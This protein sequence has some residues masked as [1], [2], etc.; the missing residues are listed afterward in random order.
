MKNNNTSHTQSNVSRR[1]F[2]TGA[3]ALT[4]S[5]TLPLD[6]LSFASLPGKKKLVV[7]MLRGGLDGLALFPPMGD[8]NYHK[9]RKGLALP[10][11]NSPGAPI[12]LNKLFGLHPMAEAFYPFWARK[13]MAFIPAA[14]LPNKDG[15][16][17][18]GQEL[19]ESGY[20]SIGSGDGTGWLGRALKL[21]KAGNEESF[22]AGDYLPLILQSKDGNGSLQFQPAHVAE[23]YEQRLQIIHEGDDLLAP[24]L[25]QA[26]NKEE[27]RL[28]RLKQDDQFSAKSAPSVIG[29]D[30]AAMLT[31]KALAR[32]NGPSVAVLETSGWDMHDSQ[33][34]SSGRLARRL[35]ALSGGMEAMVNGMAQTSIDNVWKDTV[36]VIASEF[37]RS[38]APN[39]RAGTDNGHGTS[40]ILLGGSVLGGK[41]VGTWPG[42]SE[43][44]LHQKKS[45]AYTVDMRAVFKRVLQDHLSISRTELDRTI[46]PN[47][48]AI[49][50]LKGL[51]K[52]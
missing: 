40:M 50:P 34:N 24:V 36:V 47:S 22:Y 31:G 20:G 17:F 12:K 48:G 46:F 15:S 7:I 44:Q 8:K 35:A 43:T 41:A 52:N 25:N 5:A 27:A 23:G 29:F 2:L 18:S 30:D 13:E 45:L 9:Q 49:A 16:H 26:N 10:D 39:E 33:G 14:G 19:L 4:A 42:L 51:I 32:K 21:L 37:G 11:Y 38:I 28:A 1:S 3:A 6:N